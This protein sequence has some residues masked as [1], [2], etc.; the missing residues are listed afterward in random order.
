MKNHF[1]YRNSQ[2]RDQLEIFLLSAI[3]SVLVIRF[4]LHITGYPQLGGGPLHIAHILYGGVFMAAALVVSLAFIGVRVQRL[5]A[6]LGGIGFGFFIDELGKFVTSDNNY[7]FRPAVGIM[8]AIFVILYLTFNFLSRTQKLSSR[9]YQLNAL[10]HLEEAILHDMDATEKERAHHLLLQADHRSPI[11]RHLQDLV[12]NVQLVPPDEPRNIT[13]ALNWLDRKYTDFWEMRGSN[14][15][16]R[17]FFVFESLLF[18]LVVSWG[19]FNNIDDITHLLETGTAS[20]D[21]WLF[22]GQI[23]SSIVAA[24]FAV[25]GAV[26]LAR[27]RMS[28]FEQFRRA[29]LINLYLTEFFIFSRV[30]FAAL[31]GFIFNLG[32]LL[33][34]TYI[35]H[36]ERRVR[37]H[38]KAKAGV[39]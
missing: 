23:I 21:F 25:V 37:T 4:F 31:P 3:G 24:G 30:E 29:A 17:F 27:S 26:L 38:T 9:E 10:L 22:M 6:L 18:V 34:V 35:I 33:F 1:F 8:Y 12:T 36:Q 13:K 19:I 32:V 14:R 28:A 2:A 11:T 7:F 5:A 39:A 16:V 15:L 20:Y